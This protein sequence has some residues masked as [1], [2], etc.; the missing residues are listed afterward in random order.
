[1]NDPNGM[2]HWKGRYHLFYQHNPYGPLWGN[3]HWG[4]A[5]SEDLVHWRHLPI[6]IAPTVGGPD[7]DGIFSGCMVDN[8][9]TPTAVYTGVRPECQCLAV[10]HDNLVT[11]EKHPR[12]PVIPAPPEG[13]DAGFRD[14]HV[15][16]E[17]DGWRM[18]VGS[19]RR[20]AGGAV[21]LYRSQD[22]VS[23]E[24]L[25]PL[26]EGSL[27]ETGRMWECPF[28]FPLG[29]TWVLVVHPIP[30]GRA[31][32]FVGDYRNDRFQP[33]LRG[34]VD[35]GV[36][37]FYA[38]HFFRDAR[39]RTLFMAWLREERTREA[40]ESAGW[41]GVMS[42]PR[43]AFLLPGGR[44]GSRPT[45]EV[46]RLRRRHAV[47]SGVAL[48]GAEDTVKSEVQGD[49]VE[50][51]LTLRSLQAA[52]A[53]LRVRRSPAGEEETIIVYDPWNAAVTVDRHRSSLD[54]CAGRGSVAAPLRLARGE[55]L[56]LRVFVDRSVIE[57]F[58]ASGRVTLTTRVY[59]TRPDSIGVEAFCREG[60]IER[61]DVWEMTPI[62]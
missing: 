33:A 47:R 56:S 22:L 16:R 44:L 7:K 36:G 21:L 11:W 4:H 39:N 26:F 55:P 24:C 3:M 31:I 61:L 6:A 59:P 20:N 52:P 45:P 40:Q 18:A 30:L 17:E 43:E 14:P 41:S 48:S 1:M 49:A 12:N 53:G 28:F 60:R 5:D 10:S 8:G 37:C 46:E 62:S 27:E 35:H 23:W 19:G 50:V 51:A 57:V 15:W 9:G 2:I 42:L 32:Y 29:H 54:P 25:G 58:D 38:T 34:T 13:Y